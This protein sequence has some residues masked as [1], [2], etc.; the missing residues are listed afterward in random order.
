MQIEQAAAGK[1]DSG[2]RR[3]AQHAAA[4]QAHMPEGVLYPA[5]DLEARAADDEHRPVRVTAP[6]NFNGV[7][8]QASNTEY[9]ERTFH[10]QPDR[11]FH[12]VPSTADSPALVWPRQQ[13]GF[14]EKTGRF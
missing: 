10:F 2:N 11:F 5:D 7:I 3:R 1:L 4:E 12:C 13:K 9:P 8:R 14:H 6:K